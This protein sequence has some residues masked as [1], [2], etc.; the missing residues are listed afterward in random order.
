MDVDETRHEGESAADMVLRLAKDK[1]AKSAH[2]RGRTLPVMGADTVVVCRDRVLGKPASREEG[3]EMLAWLSGE[4]HQVFTGVA[5]AAGNVI[6]TC[7]SKSTVQFRD[8]HPDEALAYWHSGE[9]ADKAGAYAIQGKGGV[10][11]QSLSGSYSGVVGL[12]IFETSM[13]LA[14]YQIDVLR[15]IADEKKT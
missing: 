11:V 15:K 5:L 13:L 6:D 7:L 2:G 9:P 14:K 12:P 4:S 8:I 10:F 1:A 3:I